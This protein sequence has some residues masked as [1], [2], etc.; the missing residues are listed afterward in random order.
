[1]SNKKTN[2]Y[3]VDSEG[4]MYNYNKESGKVNSFMDKLGNIYVYDKNGKPK[5]VDNIHN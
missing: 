3:T 2:K 4:T 5:K 1:M